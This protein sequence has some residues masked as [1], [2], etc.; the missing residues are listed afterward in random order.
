MIPLEF[1]KIFSRDFRG[2]FFRFVADGE[3]I[4]IN[5]FHFKGFR[6]GKE[7]KTLRQ[8]IEDL[9]LGFLGREEYRVIKIIACN[10]RTILVG[11]FQVLRK[12]ERDVSPYIPLPKDLHERLKSIFNYSSLMGRE[13]KNGN[14]KRKF[15]HVLLELMQVKVCPYCN[16]EFVNAIVSSEESS[17]ILHYRSPFDHFYPRSRYPMFSLSLANLIPCCTTCNSLKKEK[18][19]EEKKLRSVY[20]LESDNFITFD[21]RPKEFDFT[22]LETAENSI[23]EIEI[24]SLEKDVGNI[25]LFLLKERYQFHK[26]EVAEL[27][28]KCKLLNE[29]KLKMDKELLGEET[30]SIYRLLFA[31][32]SSKKAFLKR[33][34]A[35]LTYDILSRVASRK[36]KEFLCD[37]FP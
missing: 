31:N 30:E 12:I 1:E 3:D 4:S 19:P 9:K 35:K 20:D 33:P 32:Y 27:L 13:G 5:G 2:S 18:D 22:N 14:I 17:E 26:A 7:K 36:I 10:L 6:L 28:V 23:E 11:N 8:K 16:R 37:C 24:K 34:L 21:Y 25:S 29:D 15:G